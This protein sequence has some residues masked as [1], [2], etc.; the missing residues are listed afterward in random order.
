MVSSLILLFSTRVSSLLHT[1]Y[2]MGI[3]ASSYFLQMGI[4][5]SSHVLQWGYHRLFLLLT[6]VYCH[7]ILRQ[8]AHWLMYIVNKVLR[9]ENQYLRFTKFMFNKF[10][11]CA[12]FKPLGLSVVSSQVQALAFKASTKWLPKCCL[13]SDRR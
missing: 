7:W 5:V 4:I 2:N 11:Q 10:I 6:M 1:F 12:W 13:I 3:V 9:L 8:G